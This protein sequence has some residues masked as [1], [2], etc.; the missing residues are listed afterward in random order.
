MHIDN[1]SDIF[2]PYLNQCA[3]LWTSIKR[4]TSHRIVINP[5]NYNSLTRFSFILKLFYP[6]SL[7]SQKIII[8]R[9]ATR[10][11]LL[12]YNPDLSLPLSDVITTQSSSIKLRIATIGHSTYKAESCFWATFAIHAPLIICVHPHTVDSDASV[13]QNRPYLGVCKSSRTAP[14]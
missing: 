6:I 8:L 2:L 7:K 13:I 9:L 11:S 1:I 5:G 10:F 3:I 14:T 12:A 4:F